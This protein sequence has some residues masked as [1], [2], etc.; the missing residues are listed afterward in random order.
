ME[1]RR[2]FEDKL[3]QDP[4]KNIRESQIVPKPPRLQITKFKG[5]ILDWPRFW[6]QFKEDVNETD[7]TKTNEEIQPTEGASWRN[8]SHSG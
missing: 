2:K 8:R 1:N 6:A 4:L 3:E 5:T 7:R